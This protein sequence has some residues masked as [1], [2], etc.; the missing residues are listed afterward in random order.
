MNLG[1]KFIKVLIF[2]TNVMFTFGDNSWIC[3]AKAD[4][5]ASSP[6]FTNLEKRF[7]A[8]EMQMK[9]FQRLSQMNGINTYTTIDGFP[10]G[11]VFLLA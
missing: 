3:T 10:K 11:T 6:A 8:L 9:Q 5:I 7:N 2:S 1:L 4:S